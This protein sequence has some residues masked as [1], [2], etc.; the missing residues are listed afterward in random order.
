MRNAPYYTLGA[1]LVALAGVGLYII[2]PV[3]PAIIAWEWGC[4]P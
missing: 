4:H 1:G 3:L 2:M